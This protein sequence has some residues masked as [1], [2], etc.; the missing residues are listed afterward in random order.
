MLTKTALLFPFGSS[1]GST[2]PIR[3]GWAMLRASPAGI[4]LPLSF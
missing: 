3:V 4:A 2:F 1:P